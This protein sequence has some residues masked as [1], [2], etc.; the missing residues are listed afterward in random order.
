MSHGNWLLSGLI[1][2]VSVID[3]SCSLAITVKAWHETFIGLGS[4]STLF[5][6]DFAAI[7][8]ADT[9]VALSL[10]YF[11]RNSRTGIKKTDSL[12]SVLIMYTINTGVLTCVDAIVGLVLFAAM[13]GNLV[14]VAFYLQLS[15]LY[16]NA[17]LAT[18]NA[19]DSLR[20]RT[21]EIVSIHL[22]ELANSRGTQSGRSGTST[23][24]ATPVDKSEPL[25]I[26]VS[27]EVEMNM[28]ESDTKSRFVETGNAI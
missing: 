20:G 2:C 13:P 21:D 6:L 18:L 17:Y 9:L 3:L 22:S 28:M 7:F 8:V 24:P 19:R 5:Y 1:F 11:L 15:K 4:I 23:V 25:S 10:C 27:T 16:L 26:L 12:I 14:Y